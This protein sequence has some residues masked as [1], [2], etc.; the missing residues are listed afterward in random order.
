M[1]IKELILKDYQVIKNVK[2]ENLS[3]F[4][5]IAGPNGVGKT[6]IKDVICYIFQNNGNPPPNCSVV[7]EST[8]KQEK[9]NWGTD[10]IKL[11]HGIFWS[12]FSKP[13]KKIK[14]SARLIQIDSSRQIDSIQFQQLNFSQIGNPDEEEVGN[15]YSMN[16]VKNRFIDICNT[17][18]REK[19]KLLTDL[20]KSAYSQ[21]YTDLT[22]TV[23]TVKKIIDPTKAFEDLFYSL[24]YP[25]K[26]V[27]IDRFNH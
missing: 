8:N 6:K 18:Q 11:P 24:L 3:D 21:L 27:P 7:L 1:R 26:M 4:N 12:I 13:R 2:I 22:S 10:N 17:L 19:I 23:A 9:T 5:V 16:T 14:T 15:E 20:G 25:K